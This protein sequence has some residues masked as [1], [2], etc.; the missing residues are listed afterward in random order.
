MLDFLLHIFENRMREFEVI[1][2]NF[3]TEI[4]KYPK[5]TSYFVKRNRAHEDEAVEFLNKGIEQ[6]Y[7]RPDVNF[8]IIYRQLTLELKLSMNSRELTLFSQRELFINTVIPYIRG[9]ATPKGIE[10]I[11]RFIDKYRSAEGRDAE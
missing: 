6:G 8:V 11:D 3:F 10:I 9:C 5:V 2:P 7:F 1:T 4:G